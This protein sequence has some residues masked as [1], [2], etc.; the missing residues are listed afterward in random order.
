MHRSNRHTQDHHRAVRGMELP[1]LDE[2]H[3]LRESIRQRGQK[4]TL[5]A[6]APLWHPREASQPGESIL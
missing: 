4:Y 1:S 3:R 2:F 6:H 5:E